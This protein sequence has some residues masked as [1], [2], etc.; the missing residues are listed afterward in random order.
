MLEP[1]PILESLG[2]RVDSRGNVCQNV[3]QLA[4]M[5][6]ENTDEGGVLRIHGILDGSANIESES[7]P[8]AFPVRV[9]KRFVYFQ[10]R[11]G[12]NL[13]VDSEEFTKNA[14]SAFTEYEKL[15][16]HDMAG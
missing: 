6:I 15:I 13:R 5:S 11:S 7:G 12:D 4:L 9:T 14:L 1:K 8:L 10:T 16:K 3:N 2:Y